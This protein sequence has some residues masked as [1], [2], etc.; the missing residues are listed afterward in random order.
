ME[1]QQTTQDLLFLA[2]KEQLPPNISFVHEISELLGISYDSA[3]RRIRG[4]TELTLEETK[5]ICN[6]YKLSV[7]ALLNIRS[8]NIIFNSMAIGP[9]GIN[10]HTW[11]ANL[12]E[13]LKQ[14]HAA[15]TKEVIYSAKDIPIFHFMEF[16]LLWAFK[17][18]FWEKELLPI[19]ERAE[20]QFCRD[21]PQGVE[22]VGKT[23]LSYY[24]RIPIVEIWNRETFTSILRQLEYCYVSGYFRSKDDVVDICNQ[25]EEM[26]RHLMRQATLGYKFFRGTEPQGVEGMFRMYHNEVILGD[27]TIC[28][29]RDNTRSVH[30]TYNVISQLVTADPEFCPIVEGSLKNLM[31][32]STLISGTSEKERNKFFKGIFD[33]IRELPAS[34]D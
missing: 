2:I 5:L 27:N 23:M 9:Q 21:L 26:F 32:K 11:V 29:C 28:I 22:E 7:D 14:I 31:Q 15:H 3:Y 25:L 1:H 17:L 18:Y 13:E 10:V 4:E 34:L 20:S 12:V 24:N 33:K 19:P 30:F 16:P 8:H 6:R